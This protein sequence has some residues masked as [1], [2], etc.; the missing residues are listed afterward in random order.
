M[1]RSIHAAPGESL[2]YNHHLHQF[3]AFLKHERGFADA[4][5][6]NR[7]RKLPSPN[8]LL[9]P[10]N[11]LADIFY[12]SA[13]PNPATNKSRIAHAKPIAPPR[14]RL[15][16]NPPIASAPAGHSRVHAATRRRRTCDRGLRCCNS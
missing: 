14:Q 9:R 2:P 12:Q 5:I 6:V 15:R 8:R 11:T 13:Q 1:S 7:E 16:T 4:T 10:T 3:R